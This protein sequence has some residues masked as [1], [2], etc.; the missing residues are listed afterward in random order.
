MAKEA[1]CDASTISYWLKKN[2]INLRPCGRRRGQKWTDE[3][4]R[5]LKETRPPK[6][7]IQ[8]SPD[9]LHY[10]YED[11]HE[12]TFEIAAQVNCGP[13]CIQRRIRKLGIKP[14]HGARKGHV[15][16]HVRKLHS[17]RWK[18][19]KNPMYG[20]H[21][22]G[23]ANPMYGR[24][25]SDNPQWRGGTSFEPYCFKF[26][27]EF[28]EKIRGKFNHRCFICGGTEDVRKHHVH[29]IDYNKN[30]ICNGK[31]WAFVPLCI[32]HHAKSNKD[33]WRWFN[34]LI[35]YWAANPEINISEELH[36]WQIIPFHHHI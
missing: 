9:W 4:K 20:S 29:H 33:R 8:I 19:D 32:R 14:I 30:S 31:E 35:N 2:N 10:H 18:G 28:K 5:S 16:E 6:D 24:R 27:R 3:Q 1:D 13:D 11:L 34:L 36:E 12:T 15:S 23:N 21:R 7:R 25:G 26:N 17:E 22:V